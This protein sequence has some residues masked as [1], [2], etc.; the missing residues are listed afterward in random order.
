[1]AVALV[2]TAS[3]RRV[4]AVLGPLAWAALET[5]A[6]DA[7]LDEHRAFG[8]A[9]TVRKLGGQLQVNKDTAGRALARLIELGYLCR[10][11]PHPPRYALTGVALELFGIAIASESGRPLASDVGREWMARPVPADA[12][13]TTVTRPN[14][15]DEASDRSQRTRHRPRQQ[16]AAN[17]EQLTLIQ[18]SPND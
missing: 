8:A 10:T 14:V 11:E 6:L 15:A 5:V 17:T 3:S 1:M 2:I 12:S 7:E 13:A 18:L 4:R 9:T 16:R